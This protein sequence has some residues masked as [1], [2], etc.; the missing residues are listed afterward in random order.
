[1]KS[2]QITVSLQNPMNTLCRNKRFSLAIVKHN[3]LFREVVREFERRYLSVE[4]HRNNWNRAETA[5][6]LGMSY[7]TLLHKVAVYEL[8]S[9]T[10]QQAS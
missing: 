6:E 2:S 5:R 9:P 8:K 10:Q 7:R 1:M 4:L 3:S